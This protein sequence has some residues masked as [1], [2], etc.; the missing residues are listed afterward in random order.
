[1][2]VQTSIQAEKAM[3]TPTGKW[4][5][6][7]VWASVVQGAIAV[8]WTVFL[9]SPWTIPAAPRVIAAGGAGTWLFVGYSLYLMVGVLAVAVTAVFYM[10]IERILGKVYRGIARYLAWSHL[11][12]MNVGALGATSLMMVAG[13]LGGAAALPTNIGGQGLNAGQVHANI[14][15]VYPE[16]IFYFAG[17]AVLGVLLGGLGYILS[18]RGRQPLLPQP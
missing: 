12:L 7:F 17:V 14:M 18:A 13:Y 4:A 1:V 16:P 2:Q 15:V 10:Y 5:V 6:R 11:I 8:A 3:Q 9:I